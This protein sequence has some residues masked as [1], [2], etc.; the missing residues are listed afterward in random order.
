MRNILVVVDAQKDF[1][2][3]VLGSEDAQKAI[4]NV[5]HEIEFGG[6]DQ[7]IQTMDTHYEHT[8]MSTLEGQKL[9]VPHTLIGTEGWNLNDL[10]N[11]AICRSAVPVTVVPKETFGSVILDAVILDVL[12][13]DDP[14]YRVKAR[15]EYRLVNHVAK[16]DTRNSYDISFTIIGFDTDICVVSNALIL[17]AYF[18]NAP[19]RVIA[20]ACAGTSPE[21]HEAALAVMES[22]QIEIVR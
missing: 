2:D 10:V 13:W 18:P 8:Y 9:P 1:I 12:N 3:G 17:R 11:S 16:S 20:K 5:C 15:E 22:C 4:P 6:H 19:I 14:A 21:K 7:I